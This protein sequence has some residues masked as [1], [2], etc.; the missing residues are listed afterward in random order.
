[1]VDASLA[2]DKPVLPPALAS[3][4]RFSALCDLLWEQH[5]SLPL[6]KLLLYLIDTAPEVALLPLAEQF[7]VMGAEGW[8][9]AET[10]A[11]QRALI[12]NSIALHRT[13]G[14]PWAIK[15]VLVTLGMEGVVSEWFDYG[16]APYHFRIDVDLSGRG[17][18]QHDIARLTEL[19][20]E[21]KNA[22]SQL[23]A[24]TMNVTVRS[25]VPRIGC[26]LYSGEVLTVLP[27][28]STELVQSHVQYLAAAC[29]AVEQVSLYP[30]E[31]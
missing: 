2:F 12:K 22:R 4:P 23:E 16:G 15:Q 27:W 10:D 3:D 7:H 21:Y 8:A 30:Q 6:D 28:H 29:W 20:N 24:L 13:K 11:Q 19:V 1:M 26:A 31:P 9:V 5:A 18:G 17:M 14:T 25:N